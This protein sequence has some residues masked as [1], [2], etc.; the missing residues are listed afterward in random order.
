LVF[1]FFVTRSF[2]FWPLQFFLG[3]LFSARALGRSTDSGRVFIFFFF[4]F[5]LP[6]R[7][8]G[9]R[10][11]ATL[12]HTCIGKLKLPVFYIY[13]VSPPPCCPART[14]TERRRAERD[15]PEKRTL[16]RTAPLL[17]AHMGRDTHAHTRRNAHPEIR[18]SPLHPPSPPPF[19][20]ARMR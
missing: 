8:C 20:S 19:L 17:H 2:L 16:L 13:F 1:L 12:S 10:C 9:G 11:S 3:T 4:F 18:S 14:G 15:G 5:F 7:L 6:H